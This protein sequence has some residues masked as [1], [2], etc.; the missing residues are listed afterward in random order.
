MQN[1]KAGKRGEEITPSNT[2]DPAGERE[3]ERERERN[4]FLAWLAR[5]RAGLR[6]NLPERDAGRQ[7]RPATK[8]E[9]RRDDRLCRS[10]SA[11]ERKYARE[12]ERERESAGA[13]SAGQRTTEKGDR[14]C[15]SGKRRREE[16]CRRE[17]ERERICRSGKRRTT[18]DGEGRPPREKPATS[19][20]GEEI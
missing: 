14:I 1:N 15:L 5:D 10:G 7:R 6:Q 16:I 18:D 20:T 9:R 11:G 12:R 4:F 19:L 13:G 17:R 8:R 3:R 2:T